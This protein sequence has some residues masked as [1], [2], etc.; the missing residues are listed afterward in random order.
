[1]SSLEVITPIPQI[2]DENNNIIKNN[3]L[4]NKI[5]DENIFI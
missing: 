3:N 1:M 2:L 4:P 5:K